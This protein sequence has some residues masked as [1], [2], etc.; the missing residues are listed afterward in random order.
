MLFLLMHLYSSLEYVTAFNGET[1]KPVTPIIPLGR[2]K[3][4]Y[5][6]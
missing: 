2:E 4:L 1:T 5:V 3:A 6:I